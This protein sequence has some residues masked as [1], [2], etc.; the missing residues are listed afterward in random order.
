MRP[1]SC[2]NLSKCFACL[3]KSWARRHSASPRG[4]VAF[5]EGCP[6]Q[7]L[8]T[9]LILEPPG[10]GGGGT[11]LDKSETESLASHL[12]STA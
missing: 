7:E 8:R 3:S 11:P 1:G 9:Q 12:C 4:L 2:L 6:G 10:P 5:G